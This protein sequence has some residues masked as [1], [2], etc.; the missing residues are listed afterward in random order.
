MQEEWLEETIA[1]ENPALG[2]KLKGLRHLD[3]RWK[4]LMQGKE[5]KKEE[6][7]KPKIAIV[8]DVEGWAFHNIAKEIKK[9]LAK[10]F[11]IT[12]LPKSAFDDN[13]VKMLLLAKHF[14]LMHVMWRGM[15]SELKCDYLQNYMKTLG[16]EKEEFIEKYVKGNLLTTSVYDH[17][18]LNPEAFWITESFLD[19]VKGYTV[20]SQKLLDI[21]QNLPISLKPYGE[22][23]DGVDL[24]R[25]QPRNL[26]RFQTI[27]NRKVKIGWVGNSKFLDSEN[28][29]D[30]KGV[31]SIINPAIDELIEEGYPIEKNFADR[32]VKMI[33]HSEMPN[34][35][36]TI[37]VYICASKQ[38]GTPN[39]VLE[40][41]ACGIPVISTDVGIVSEALGEK[42]KEFILKERTKE[43]LKEKIKQ[44]LAN[45]ELWQELSKENRQRIQSWSW[46][47]K[48]EQFKKFFS[49]ILEE[50]GKNEKK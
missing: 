1:K 14:D 6:T 16:F 39:P 31:R 21:Y 20:S 5:E 3:K 11:D 27:G 50:E 32:N 35:Y 25:F 46:A 49:K 48:C 37:D 18:F 42:Q 38:E 33:P 22:I 30:L 2:R 19:C 8:Y 15:F 44:L 7:K 17:S 36:E 34:Y 43:E 13:V 29:E 40:S 23:S 41:M 4:E 45:P 10:D 47:K 9:Y 12:I 26:E 24:E 28:D